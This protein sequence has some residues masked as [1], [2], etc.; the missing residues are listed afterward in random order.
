MTTPHPDTDDTDARDALWA[1]GYA[2]RDERIIGPRLAARLRRA[3]RQQSAMAELR[4][5]FL[6]ATPVRQFLAL[7][8]RW[9]IGIAIAAWVLVLFLVALDFALR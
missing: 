3:D 7:T 4:R 2:A 8:L 9:Y 6:A 5:A 1:I